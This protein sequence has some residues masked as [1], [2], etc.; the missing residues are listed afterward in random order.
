MNINVFIG[1]QQ[2]ID[3]IT[4]TRMKGVT[5]EEFLYII[6]RTVCIGGFDYHK[7]ETGYWIGGKNP[8]E[9]RA[10]MN[11]WGIMMERTVFSVGDE[12]PVTVITRLPGLITIIDPEDPTFVYYGSFRVTTNDGKIVKDYN[13]ITKSRLDF[14]IPPIKIKKDCY[15][16]QVSLNKFC[17]LP[18]GEYNIQFRYLENE[19]P[20][21]AIEIYDRQVNQPSMK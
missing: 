11:G 5:F 12:I 15:P 18:A 4:T 2:Y 3:V 19:T 16:I 20:S 17:K 1:E 13:P 7:T 14:T 10:L 21:I 8:T 6:G 9:P